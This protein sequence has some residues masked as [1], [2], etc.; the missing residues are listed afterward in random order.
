MASRNPTPASG[1]ETNSDP[2]PETGAACASCGTVSTGKFCANCGAPLAG[3]TCGSCTAPLTP[4]ARF[5]HRCGT[6]AGADNPAAERTFASAVPWAVAGIALVSLIALA[7]GQ[8]FGRGPADATSPPDAGGANAAPF[9]GATGNGP[10]PDISKLS[11]A[12]AAVR[13][14]NRVMGAY[15]RGQTDT[16]QLFAP[17]AITAY[18]MIGALDLDQRY[19]MGRIAA[20]SGDEALA[21]AE[22]DT[23]L[24]KH[25]NHL[26][27][28]ILAGDAARLRKDA[29]GARAFH[30]KLV[31]AAPGERAKKVPE[32]VVHEND[33]R[34]ALDPKRP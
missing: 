21:R 5:C 33:I 6:P 30:E 29:A 8:R 11:P 14:Y 19:D 4:G 16:V 1:A 18:Q 12:Q 20:I 28:L 13:L 31:A 2:T 17:M 15:E 10:A 7:A 9:A 34:I 24:A 26:L 32:Y 22:A 3:A 27:G 25:P 23:I